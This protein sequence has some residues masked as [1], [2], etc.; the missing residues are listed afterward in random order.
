MLL[1]LLCSL[2]AALPMASQAGSLVYKGVIT[3]KAQQT[4]LNGNNFESTQSQNTA[5][6]N[7][8]MVVDS[9]GNNDRYVVV[10]DRKN[11]IFTSASTPLSK[12]PLLFSAINGKSSKKRSANAQFYPAGTFQSI[13]DRDNNL[14]DDTE[15]TQ[16]GS[17]FG[18][19]QDFNIDGSPV[20][21]PRRLTGLFT[22]LRCSDVIPN[23]AGSGYIDGTEVSSIIQR[24]IL[25]LDMRDTRSFFNDTVAD[26]G[27]SIISELTNQ[28]N[29]PGDPIFA[30]GFESGDVTAWSSETP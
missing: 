7:V 8:V 5:R 27:S 4:F 2:L 3:I 17:L 18:Q 13:T 16:T 15:T 29:S 24:V 20:F 14:M 28:G 26:T 21:A 19:P 10:L 23:P 12:A 30:D 22:L 11:R 6:Y 9:T 1:V 25:R